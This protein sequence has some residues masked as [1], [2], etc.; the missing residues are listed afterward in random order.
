MSAEAAPTP[1]PNAV[2]LTASKRLTAEDPKLSDLKSRAQRA[3]AIIRVSHDGVSEGLLKAMNEALDL[4]EVVKVKFVARKDE[5]KILSR[6]IEEK[7]DSVMVQRV[8]HTATYY[9]RKKSGK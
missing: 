7:T 5:K 4:H 1:E 8:G 6:V 2:E 3:Q 9:R